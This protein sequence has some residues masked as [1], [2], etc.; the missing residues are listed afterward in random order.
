MKKIT[1]LLCLLLAGCA[2]AS[3]DS[4][5][6]C[7]A[8]KTGS[9]TAVD[10]KEIDDIIVVFSKAIKNNPDYAGAYYNRAAAY[11]HK[12]DYDKSWQD[13]HKAEELGIKVD[14]KFIELVDKLKKAS[15]RDR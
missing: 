12:N 14:A 13:I 1:V 6:P 3:R 7:Q 4:K 2:T 9:A 15:G 5:I 11:F 10:Q 8:V